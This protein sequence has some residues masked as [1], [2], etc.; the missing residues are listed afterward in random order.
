MEHASYRQRRDQIETYFDRTALDSWKRLTGEEKVSGIRATVRAGRA[1]MRDLLLS[2]FAGDIRGMRILDACCGSG[3]LGL[4]LARRGADVLGIDLSAGM[5]RHGR[6]SMP[7]IE[8]PGRL[9]LMCG[10]MLSPTL[11]RFDAVVAMDSLIH[12][13]RTDVA[14]ALSDL[15][16][17]VNRKIVFT[18]APRTVPLLLMHSAGKLFPRSDRSP[19]IEPVSAARLYHSL[20]NLPEFDGWKGIDPVRVSKGFYISEACEMNR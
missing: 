15:A 11:G 10:D 6:M 16:G 3:Q 13:N 9:D 7:A 14:R 12:Y 20:L 5:I 18:L 8:G 19:A 1:E 4:E 17:R 2:R